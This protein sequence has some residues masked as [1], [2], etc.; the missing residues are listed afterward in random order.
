MLRT[1]RT[2]LN[3]AHCLYRTALFVICLHYKTFLF[4]S[5]LI[6]IELAHSSIYATHFSVIGALLIHIEHSITCVGFCVC[7]PRT[8][9]WMYS[10]AFLTANEVDAPDSELYSPL[11]LRA[12]IPK[13]VGKAGLTITVEKQGAVGGFR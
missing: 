10:S 12:A 6:Y 9:L 4:F 8:A 7:S 11:F 3:T 2:G 1:T 13:E 5:T